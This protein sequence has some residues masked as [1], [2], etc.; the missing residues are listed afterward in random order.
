[1]KRF[2]RILVCIDQPERDSRM[3]AYTKAITRFADSKEVHIL[4]VADDQER[5]DADSSAPAAV[6][7]E[8]LRAIAGEHFKDPAAP[9]C[10]FQVVQGSP[11]IEILRFGYE[12]DV[13]LI[14]IGLQHGEDNETNRQALMSRRLTRKATCS[15]LAL[16]EEYEVKAD[17]ILVPV[18]N[19]DC[20][21]NALDVACAIAAETKARVIPFNVYRLSVGYSRVGATREEHEALLDAAAQHECELLLKGIDTRSVAVSC[22]TAP[23]PHNKPVPVILEAI[24]RASADLVVIGARGRTGMAG[25]LLGAV[26]DQLISTSTVPVL[27][28]KTKGE[29]LGIVRA[30]LA[31]A[32]EG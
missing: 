14:V 1:M 23:D 26:T 30:L 11:L 12:K 17:M 6:T 20:S 29:C 24:E 7:E 5:A 4:H 27:A 10:S 22:E 9:K 32:G 3:L 21:A 15:V 18:R 25:V 28:V 19:S 13:D 8:T 2:E 16:P 31:L